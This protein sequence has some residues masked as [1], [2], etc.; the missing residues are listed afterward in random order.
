MKHAITVGL[1]VLVAAWAA[2]WASGP[3]RSEG[4]TSYTVLSAKIDVATA[5]DHAIIT[6]STSAKKIVV[7]SLFFVCAAANN[8]TIE[9]S[10]SDTDLTGSMNFAANGGMALDCGFDGCFETAAAGDTLDFELSAAQSVDG[11]IRYYEIE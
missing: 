9:S 1:V 11:V 7:T 3:N 4:G 5:A 6:P 10:T 2:A 8:I